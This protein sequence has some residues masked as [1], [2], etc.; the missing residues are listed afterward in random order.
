MN[1]IYE[2]A[3]AEVYQILLCFP[4]DIRLKIP[5]KLLELIKKEKDKD[6]KVNIK[7]P[8]NTGDYSKEAIVLLGMIYTDYLCAP[9]EKNIR[10]KRALELKQIYDKQNSEKYNQDNIFK[11]VNNKVENE[12]EEISE[13]NMETALVQYKES[14]FARFKNFIFK[15]LHIN[16]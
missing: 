13:N 11:K 10:K 14:F 1:N 4:E 5:K 12:K 9:E 7:H 15:I 6:Y 3:L 8:L 16:K 2:K